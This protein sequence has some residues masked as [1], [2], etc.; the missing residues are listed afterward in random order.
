M[1]NSEIL[2]KL[3]NR[4]NLSQSYVADKMNMHKQQFSDKLKRNSFK[5][6]ELI[7]IGNI[8]GAKY[9]VTKKFVLENEEIF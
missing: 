9:I 8:V 5:E 2:I 1:N 4:L 7:E 6:E 3:L